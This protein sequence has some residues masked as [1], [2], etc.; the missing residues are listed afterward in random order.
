MH[1]LHLFLPHC[2]TGFNF[3]SAE[4]LLWP[5]PSLSIFH[6]LN[7][8]FVHMRFASVG[9]SR[10]CSWCVCGYVY[11]CVGLT[12]WTLVNT[13]LWFH[14]VHLWL[15]IFLLHYQHLDK[16]TDSCL[17]RQRLLSSFASICGIWQ[18][19]SAEG[20]PHLLVCLRGWTTAAKTPLGCRTDQ[21]S[22]TMDMTLITLDRAWKEGEG[23]EKQGGGAMWPSAEETGEGKLKQ[24]EYGAAHN[25]C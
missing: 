9:A 14:Y 17:H 3:F 12:A 10:Q 11:V 1:K 21:A 5:K 6:W 25:R 19:G 15:W 23:V 24:L 8:L 4:L 18:C 13:S 7:C 20:C 22:V 2:P 16:K